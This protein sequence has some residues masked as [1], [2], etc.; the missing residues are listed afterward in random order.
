MATLQCQEDEVN[1]LQ[2][3]YGNDFED[4][5]KLDPSKVRTH[6]HYIHKYI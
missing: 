6:I 3:I 5:R 4:L 2:S 1:V